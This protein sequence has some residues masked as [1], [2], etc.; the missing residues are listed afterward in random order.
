MSCIGL[1]HAH[2]IQS[3]TNRFGVLLASLLALL[4]MLDRPAA[5]QSGSNTPSILIASEISVPPAA[6]TRMPVAV[7]AP[8]GLPV[9]AM[10][11]FRGLPERVMLSEGRRFNAGVWAV[12]VASVGRLEIAPAIEASGTSELAIELTTLDG[13]VLATASTTLSIGQRAGDQTKTVAATQDEPI[14][15]TTG[16]INGATSAI[17][18]TTAVKRLSAED[19]GRARKMMERGDEAL[20][21]GKITAARLLYQ[22]AADA[23]WAP[24]AFALAQ[25]YDSRV[26]SQ[27]RVLGGVQ[28]DPALAKKWYEKARELGSTEAAGR[29]QALR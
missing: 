9:G 3:R 24:G 1:R 20:A 17:G 14:L 27:S 11:V 19:A 16:T 18:T 7:N 26:L 13:N 8:R 10:L 23:G 12:P 15:R 5:A 21:G 2:R 22:A 29:L 4:G 25:T 6:V 28:P